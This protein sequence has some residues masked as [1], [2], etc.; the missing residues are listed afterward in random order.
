MS[1]FELLLT[2]CALAADAFAVAM[3]NGLCVKHKR[4]RATVMGAVIFGL[5][6]GLMP[7]IGYGLGMNFARY[8]ER[9]DHWVALI[10]LGFIGLNMIC[11]AGKGDG[12]ADIQV[13]TFGA[14]LVQGFA[15]SVDALAVGVSFAALDVNIVYAAA[16]ICAVTALIAFGGFVIGHKF[17]GRL[18]SKA[19]I[20]GGVA[21]IMIGFKIFAQHVF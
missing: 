3:T 17:S 5:F 13:L 1:I 10:L 15:T 18:G 9:Y 20:V 6:Q 4:L 7:T 8:I 12:V 16:F 19:Q 14:V 2:A 21:L 11:G